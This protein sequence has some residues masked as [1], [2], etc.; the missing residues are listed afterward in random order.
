MRFRE[1]PSCLG[2]RNDRYSLNLPFQRAK[3]NRESCETGTAWLPTKVKISASW[4]VAIAIAIRDRQKHIN[5]TY[6]NPKYLWPFL[7]HFD[8]K[9][10]LSKPEYVNKIK[11]TCTSAHKFYGVLPL[12]MRWI[13][14]SSYEA[15]V[16]ATGGF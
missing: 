16:D 1:T 14:I 6:S 8:K 4:L 11:S 15:E 2:A 5:A 10:I 7:F 13:P 3:L 9:V 12:V